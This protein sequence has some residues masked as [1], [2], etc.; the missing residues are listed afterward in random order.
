MR[1]RSP[2]LGKGELIGRMREELDRP[3]PTPEYIRPQDQLG[4]TPER[5]ARAL[6]AD[7][8][9]NMQEVEFERDN[10]NWRAYRL[11]DAPLGRLLTRKRI[12]REQFNAG[13]C[14]Y[15]VVYYAGMMGAGP[16][17]TDRIIVDGGRHKDIPERLIAA[18]ARWE[19]IVKRMDYPLLHICDAIIVQEIPLAEYA[20]RFRRHTERRVRQGVALD[21]LIMGLDWLAL[22]FG[23]KETRRGVVGGIAVSDRPI[24]MPGPVAT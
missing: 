7:G 3:A 1:K 12:D 19:L 15:G 23:T 2:P 6:D 16:P 9:S 10:V 18:K 21:R 24:I 20:E 13:E 14:Y 4:P 11:A 5:L 17:P 8:I 22:H